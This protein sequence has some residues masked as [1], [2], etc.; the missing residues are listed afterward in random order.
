MT[1]D[2]LKEMD[3]KKIMRAV[4]L[5]FSAA[6]DIIGFSAIHLIELRG[7]SLMEASLMS[8]M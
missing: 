2:W 6:F 7:F 1:D 8:S 4:V 5:D 3:N